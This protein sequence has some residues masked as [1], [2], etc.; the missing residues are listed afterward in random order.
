MKHCIIGLVYYPVYLHK[1]YDIITYFRLK[2]LINK[3]L[4][5]SFNASVIES[6]NMLQFLH[7]SFNSG[8]I[9]LIIAP[10]LSENIGSIMSYTEDSLVNFLYP[11]SLVNGLKIAVY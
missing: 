7:M 6:G 3:T 10:L 8:L 1:P 2:L 5:P 9:R 11:K 4:F